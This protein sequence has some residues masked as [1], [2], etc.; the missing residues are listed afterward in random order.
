MPSFVISSVSFVKKIVLLSTVIPFRVLYVSD[1]QAL[2][3][4]F[5]WEWPKCRDQEMYLFLGLCRQGASFRPSHHCD[6]EEQQGYWAEEE[7]DWER[8]TDACLR[9]SWLAIINVLILEIGHY[10]I[11]HTFFILHE[12]CNHLFSAKF[13]HLFFVVMNFFFSLQWLQ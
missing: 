1:S 5:L 11:L 7:G 8:Q 2:W 3:T 9:G 6:Q 4:L 12:Y 13:D 10:S